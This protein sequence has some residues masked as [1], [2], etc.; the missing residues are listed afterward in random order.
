MLNL[1]AYIGTYVGIQLENNNKEP[2]KETKD[3]NQVD[4]IALIF[5]G[6]LL[7]AYGLFSTYRLLTADIESNLLYIVTPNLILT[8][9]GIIIGFLG[10]RQ[11]KNRKKSG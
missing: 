3:K 10:L 7:V 6:V 1:L 11:E 4:P 8:A 9:F 2:E 5:W